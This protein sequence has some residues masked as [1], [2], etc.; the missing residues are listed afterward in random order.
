MHKE[1]GAVVTEVDYGLSEATQGL[2]KLD[3]RK[4]ELKDMEVARKLQ[5]EELKV[6]KRHLI[7]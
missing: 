5:E 6:R 1:S 2:M 4:Q 3:V 7:L